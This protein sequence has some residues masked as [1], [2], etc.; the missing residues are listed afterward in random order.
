MIRPPLWVRPAS[1]VLFALVM[2][3]CS[4]AAPGGSG[5]PASRG[6]APSG[7]FAP[8][9]TPAA[10]PPRA[11]P[12]TPAPTEPFTIHT[13]QLPAG[14]YL[15]SEFSPPLSFTIGPGWRAYFEGPQDL[16]FEDAGQAAFGATRLEKGVDPTTHLGTPAPPDLPPW[17]KKHP[18]LTGVTLT[19]VTV[20]GRPATLV[21][22]TATR[23]QDVYYGADGNFRLVGGVRY[24]IYIVPMDGPDLVVTTV[25]PGGLLD[26][27]APELQAIVDS[28]RI[29][30]P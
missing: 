20:A 4:T 3:A 6:P 16:Y 26:A 17:F 25:L 23:T 21:E 14:K 29:V 24:R 7:T 9:A 12:A 13:G 22:G 15:Q 27:A 28:L 8:T 19:S 10:F 2:A 18:A 1:G 11:A 30:G 5:T